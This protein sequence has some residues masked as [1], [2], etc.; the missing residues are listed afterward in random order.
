MKK[1]TKTQFRK[2]LL[3]NKISLKRMDKISLVDVVKMWFLKR[4]YLHVIWKRL[5]DIAYSLNDSSFVR[6][7]DFSIKNG[8]DEEFDGDKGKYAFNCLV[9]FLNKYLIIDTD[10]KQVI[11]DKIDALWHFLLQYKVRV[12]YEIQTKGLDLL[13]SILK[14]L[15]EEINKNL[16]KGV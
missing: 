10:D 11:D 4:P 15:P 7:V 1:I 6:F 8:F 14:I 12:E 2:L 9:F 16:Y 3:R 13:S 5:E